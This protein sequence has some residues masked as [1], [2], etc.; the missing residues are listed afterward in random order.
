MNACTMTPGPRYIET[1]WCPMMRAMLDASS[2]RFRVATTI[3]KATGHFSENVII[4]LGPKRGFAF[5]HFCPFCGA[6][7]WIDDARAR[8]EVP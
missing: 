8:V 2:R 5:A 4:D 7:V 1:R 3:S 6:P